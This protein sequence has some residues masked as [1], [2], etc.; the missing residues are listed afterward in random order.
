MKKLILTT[1]VCWAMTAVSAF[2]QMPPTWSDY[3]MRQ[4]EYPDCEYFTGYA[5]GA[6]MT[7]ERQEVATQRLKDAARVEAVSTIRVHITNQS[8]N[9]MVSQQLRLT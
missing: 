6:P 2:A 9:D 7:G 1:L 4:L 3:D 8:T 5:E